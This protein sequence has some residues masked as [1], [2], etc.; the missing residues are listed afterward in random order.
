MAYTD[1]IAP[2]FAMTALLAALDHRRRTGV[3]Q[4]VDLS[5][6]ECS[7]HFLG[8]AI[9][10]QTTNGRTATARGNESRDSAPSGVYPASGVERWIAID[11]PDESCWQALAATAN[12]GWEGDPRFADAGARRVNNASL[13]E[14]IAN[15]TSRQDVERLENRLQSAGVPAHRVST[16]QDAF[17]DPQL[18]ARQ[19]FV[20]L[21]HPELGRV[22]YESTRAILS[23]TPARPGPCPT[24]GQ[25]NALV[26]GEILG[27]PDDEVTELIIA[28]AI[29]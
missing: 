26:L 1:Y 8:S 12:E 23:S 25:H 18:A 7:I 17:E 14:L 11:A 19:H 27:L 22:P 5:Q 28:G 2:R 6:T 9:L 20:W 24:L 21:E 16:S 4:H 29:E 3:G 10:D 15:W 13:D